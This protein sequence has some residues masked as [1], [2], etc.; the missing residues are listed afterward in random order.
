MRGSLD[1]GYETS[2]QVLVHL[3]R[4]VLV[5]VGDGFKGSEPALE[6]HELSLGF[7]SALDVG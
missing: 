7:H 2:L 5:R 3:A 6:L 4:V 1:N